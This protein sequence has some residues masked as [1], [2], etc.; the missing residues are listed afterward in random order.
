MYDTL[1]TRKLLV[2]EDDDIEAPAEKSRI[3]LVNLIRNINNQPVDLQLTELTV[4]NTAI[5]GVAYGQASPYV[6][7]VSGSYDFNVLLAGN[8]LI[9]TSEGTPIGVS[10]AFRKT[11][12]YT[13]YL[14]GVAGLAAN[15]SPQSIAYKA[16]LHN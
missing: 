7:V 14:Y 4:S 2:L 15:S 11:K 6:E 13:L 5:R 8:P 16:I 1:P 3:R 9:K 12:S 10:I